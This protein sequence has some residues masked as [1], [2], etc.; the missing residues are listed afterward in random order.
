M[1][2]LDPG[3]HAFLFLFADLQARASTASLLLEA[4]LPMPL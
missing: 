4:M 3:I 2:G 1:P